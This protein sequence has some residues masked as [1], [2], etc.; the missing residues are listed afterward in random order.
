LLLCSRSLGVRSRPDR[1]A[2]AAAAKVAK[3]RPFLRVERDA[4]RK[5]G[6]A[7]TSLAAAELP[8]SQRLALRR[9]S[10]RLRRHLR[11]PRRPRLRS[12][13][14]L[15]SRPR[16]QRRALRLKHRPR[17]PGW[18]ADVR[19]RRLVAALVLLASTFAA[20]AACKGGGDPVGLGGARPYFGCCVS[21][22]EW[23]CATRNGCTS[24]SETSCV[25]DGPPM[26]LPQCGDRCEQMRVDAMKAADVAG[27]TLTS[28]MCN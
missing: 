3:G 28:R 25:C 8:R 15:R 27:C 22:E 16:L 19:R 2:K 12:R 11:R 18:A 6:G 26:S 14:H 24:Y 23:D 5:R 13:P 9:L 1:T 4:I 20:G 17:A 21:G 7:V 10:H